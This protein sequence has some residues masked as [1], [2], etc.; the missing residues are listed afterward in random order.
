MTFEQEC[1]VK[2]TLYYPAIL[3][4]A[5][6]FSLHPAH[7]ESVCWI[8]GRTDLLSCLFSFLTI[9]LFMLFFQKRQVTPLVLSLFSFCVALLCKENAILVPLILLGY[10][11]LNHKDRLKTLALSLPRSLFNATK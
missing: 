10:T 3:I 11:L 7:V 9:I 6:L 5:L 4:V 2:R 1:K 8:S